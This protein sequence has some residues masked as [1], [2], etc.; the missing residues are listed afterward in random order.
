[1]MSVFAD[2]KKFFEAPHTVLILR[3]SS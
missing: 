1:M 2:G 3:F